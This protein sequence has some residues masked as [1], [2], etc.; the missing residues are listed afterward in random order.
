MEPE[1]S[2]PSTHEDDE[3]HTL[4]NNPGT[5]YITKTLIFMYQN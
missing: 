5:N 3:I 4:Q 2:F 1:G